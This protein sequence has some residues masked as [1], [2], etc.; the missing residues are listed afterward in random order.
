VR[1]TRELNPTV[2][3]EEIDR[4]YADDPV[5]AAT[6]F[7]A[8]FRSDIESFLTREALEGAV[9]PGRLQLPP[10]TGIR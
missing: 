7:G 2:P 6:E 4:A 5:R 10:K 1:T 3:Q 8:T 9:V